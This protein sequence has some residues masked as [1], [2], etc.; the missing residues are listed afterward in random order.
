MKINRKVEYALIAL[1]HLQLKDGSGLVTAK[2]LGDR[3]AAPYDVLSKVLQTLASNGILHSE[4]GAH[5]GYRLAVELGSLTIYDLNEA[6]TGPFAFAYCL[7][8]TA[9]GCQL[10]PQCNVIS[11]ILQLSRR[12]EDLYRG[13]SVADLFTA[14]DPREPEI[15]RRFA[16]QAAS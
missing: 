5:G 16:A 11:P 7:R 14:S 12:V 10:T 8:D 3:Y 9:G 15:R 4:Q 2:E 1:R 13:V 6:L